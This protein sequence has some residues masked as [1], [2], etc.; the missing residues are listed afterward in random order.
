MEKAGVS[1]LVKRLL[2]NLYWR[3]HAAVRWDGEISRQVVVES[4]SRQGCVIPSLLFNLYSEF[5][6]KEAIRNEQ[7]IKFNEIKI[8]NLRYADDEVFVVVTG[9][10]AED[11][12]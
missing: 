3:L 12:R 5:M 4:E 8:T 9:E 1:E 2:V 10:N 6:I 11:D 7:G